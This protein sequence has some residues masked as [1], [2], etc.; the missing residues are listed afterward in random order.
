MLLELGRASEAVA[1][2]D[3]ALAVAPGDEDLLAFRAQAALA[4]GPS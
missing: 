4:R 1:G 3:A 2:F